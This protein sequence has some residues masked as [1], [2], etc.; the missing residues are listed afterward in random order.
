MELKHLGR[1]QVLLN[2]DVGRVDA[3]DDSSLC[4]WRAEGVNN[5]SARNILIKEIKSHRKNS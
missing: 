1:R 5:K 2:R 3:T 4:E